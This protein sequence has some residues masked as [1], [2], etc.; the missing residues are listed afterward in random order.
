[1]RRLFIIWLAVAALA[2]AGYAQRGTDLSGTWK[3]NLK[4]SYFGMNHS[5]S[6]LGQTLTIEQQGLNFKETRILERAV[7]S[8]YLR[9]AQSAQSTRSLVA[10]GKPQPLPPRDPNSRQSPTG[11]RAYWQGGCLIVTEE[12]G[13]SKTRRTYFLSEDGK[14]MTILVGSSSNS[15]ESEQKLIF[16]KQ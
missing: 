4:Q 12:A 3:L 11:L 16:D 7:S 14:Q 2:A 15:S 10:D 6:Q 9:N 1:M 13:M 8:G 5:M